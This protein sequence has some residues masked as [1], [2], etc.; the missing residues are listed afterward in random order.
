MDKAIQEKHARFKTYSAQKKGGMVAEAKRIL[1]AYNWCQAHDK[2]CHLAGKV[3]VGKQEITTASPDGDGVFFIA[4]QM[5]HKN[6]E[7]V[8]ENCLRNDAGEF[9]LI[10]EDKMKV[11]LSTMLGCWMLNLCGQATSSLRRYYQSFG[12]I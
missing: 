12:T 5:D 9:V 1:T 7:I 10:D 3:R 2:I 8:G 6:Q 11:W 4:K